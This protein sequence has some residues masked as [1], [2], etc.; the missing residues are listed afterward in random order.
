MDLFNSN[1]IPNYL[2]KLYIIK[3][4]DKLDFI[5]II[6]IINDKNL[7]NFF[8]KNYINKNNILKIYSSLNN[9]DDNISSEIKKETSDLFYN[10]IKSSNIRDLLFFTIFIYEDENLLNQILA[11]R[12][13]K[14]N[15]LGRFFEDYFVIE[16]LNKYG[17]E[18]NLINKLVNNNYDKIL[19]II[20]NISNPSYKI[21]CATDKGMEIYLEKSNISKSIKKFD[22]TKIFEILK[23]DSYSMTLKKYIININHDNLL[24]YFYLMNIN[25]YFYNY[26]F[27]LGYSKIN[28][29][30]F[31]NLNGNISDFLKKL[32]IEDL[33]KYNE[34]INELILS[35]EIYFHDLIDKIDFNTFSFINSDFSPLIFKK[36]FKIYNNYILE[37][38]KNLDK[39]VLNYKMYNDNEDVMIK[40]FVL[41]VLYPNKDDRENVK[42]LID[43][44]SYGVAKK[45]YD[46]IKMFTSMLDIDLKLFI[47]Y[48][49]ISNKPINIMENIINQNKISKYKEFKNFLDENY[50]YIINDAKIIENFNDSLELYNRYNTLVDKIDLTNI[51]DKDKKIYYFL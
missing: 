26:K 22:Y 8:I 32:T 40:N 47:Q 7:R 1:K 51:S 33:I 48:G 2:K 37:K 16:F 45:Y 11:I 29:E 21:L 43:K 50:Y 12:N 30:I 49:L 24:K 39:E 38:F 46:K 10:T 44:F 42:A 9:L 17:N 13:L 35:Q 23:S 41:K 34:S 3:H 31:N 18:N 25:K 15:D 28:I 14:I 27:M 20:K 36:I 5:S 19:N 4:Q 6:K